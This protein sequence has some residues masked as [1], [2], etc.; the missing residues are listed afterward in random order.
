MKLITAPSVHVLSIPQFFPHPKYVLPPHGNDN[1]NIIATA[2]K[3]CYDT[4][5]PSGNPVATHVQNLVGK[6]QQHFSVIEHVNVGL[7]IEGVSRG[8]THELVRHRHFSY[9]QRSTRYTEESEAAIVLD[10]YYAGIALKEDQ[11][12][13]AGEVLLLN[14]FIS[15]CK[16]ALGEYHDQVD[17][18]MS[19]NPE[20]LERRDLRKWARGKARQLLPHALESR[21]VMTGNLRSWRELLIKRSNI[22]AEKEMRRLTDKLIDVL[23]PLAPNAF[24]GLRLTVVEGYVQVTEVD[25]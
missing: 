21:L 6:Q 13:L 5:G 12:Q 18:L 10:P 3:V 14:R 4:Y 8:L 19:L 9:S 25:E 24:A 15:Q 22:G 1:E 16:Q 20:R 7:F 11:S 2:G 17:R 23:L